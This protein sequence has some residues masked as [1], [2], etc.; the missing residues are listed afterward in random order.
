MLNDTFAKRFN[1]N[2]L[3][4]GGTLKSEAAGTDAILTNLCQTPNLGIK[5]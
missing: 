1:K 4:S 3:L 2:N 5:P